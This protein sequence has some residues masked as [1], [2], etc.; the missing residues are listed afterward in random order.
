MR[1]LLIGAPGAGKGTQ[2]VTLPSGSAWRTSP[3]VTCCAST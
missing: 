2:A 1:L 3:A